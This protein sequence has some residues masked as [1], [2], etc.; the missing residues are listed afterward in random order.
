M[1]RKITVLLLMTIGLS[2][3]TSKAEEIKVG[4]TTRNMIVYAPQNLPQ[5][6]P[7]IISMHGFR[8]DAPY[9][10]AQ[11]KW[12]PIADT[13]KFVVVYPN[14]IEKRWDIT[15]TSDIDFI[16]A[17]IDNMNSRYGIDR[18]RVYLSGFSMG[19]MMSYY[20]ITKIADKI[21]A[22][23]PISGYMMA[24]PNTNTTRPMPIIHTH[25]TGDDVVA[26][27]GVET[28]L[29]AWVKRNGCPE[30]AKITKPYPADKPNSIAT[31]SYWGP[32][33]KG[34][35]IVLMALKDKGHWISNDIV[36]GIHTSLEIWKFIQKFSLNS[37][38]VS[39]K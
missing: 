16:L 21:A 8:Q 25:G 6:R 39:S 24:G 20:A 18:N 12:E 2:L 34:S 26:F 31:K 22:I 38:T 32:G 37:N 11:A 30:M 28:C 9:Q 29:N 3:S 14:A 7:L 17:I 15:G 10:Q 19:G 23:A 4:N 1:V 13:A 5:N 27:A 35:E 33:E 36:N